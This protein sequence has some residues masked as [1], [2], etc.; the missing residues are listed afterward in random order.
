[1]ADTSPRL[2]LPYLQPSQAQKHVTHNEALQRLDAV[3]QTSV[4]AFD[5]ETPPTAP[6]AG[7]L[8]ALGPAP[9]GAW[10]GQ[11]GQ[12]ALWDGVAW[13][14]HAPGLGW[15]AWGVSEAALRVYDGTAWVAAEGDLQNRAG[16]GIGAAWDATNRLAVASPA[17]LLTAETDDIQVKLN[18]AAAGDTASL[19]MQTGFSGRAEIGLTGD[20]DLHVKV[21]PDG[22]AWSE[23]LVLDRTTGA[24]ALAAGLTVGGA[25]AY[26][27]G[28]VL[29]TVAQSG[30][31]PTGAIVERGS[32]ANGEYV[33]FA[34]G[35]L[36]CYH[37]LISSAAADTTW[38]YPA[39]F[40]SGP[41]P[42]NICANGS[43][44]A[45]RIANISGTPGTTSLAFILF[46][47]ATA[48]VSQTARVMAAGEWF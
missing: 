44:P 25:P 38:T 2:D 15:R 6:D 5:A 27:Q 8:H 39:A 18:K 47:T 46:S 37:T 19:L 20:D 32:N 10:A 26:H 22:T 12:L 41:T 13:Q 3:V 35:T 30:G 9:T 14:F 7:E 29:G 11:A 28:N 42:S 31:V 17:V 24:A 4:A 23:A 40:I 16:L 34:D 21:S 43:G 33:K 48:R 1:M 45:A 36:I